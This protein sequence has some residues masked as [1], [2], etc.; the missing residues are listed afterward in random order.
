MQA[1]PCRGGDG[2]PAFGRYPRAL[3]PDLAATREEEELVTLRIKAAAGSLAVLLSLAAC[4]S[5]EDLSKRPPQQIINDAKTAAL[6]AKSVHITGTLD[7]Q[8]SK[9]N[10]DIVL[11]NNGDGKEDISAGG[12]TISVIK[13]GNTV[14]VKGGPA[15][16][17][18]YKKL[19]ADDPQAKNLAA[20]VDKKAF[21]NQAF[22]TKQQYTV[23]GTGKVGDQ[24]TLKLT[25]KEG[26]PVLHV[27]NDADK[28]YPMKI[29]GTGAKGAISVTFADWDSDAKITAPPT[30]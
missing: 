1:Y 9:G 26:Q 16:Q 27:A 10:V 19:P 6:A 21:I 11:T 7:Q 15:G 20:A 8:G 24:E 17:G 30:S 14:Y 12:Q 23:T 4:G 22:D 5:G 29:E 28:P 3:R 18:G 13:V 2:G 25:P